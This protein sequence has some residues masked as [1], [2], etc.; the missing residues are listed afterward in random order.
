MEEMV[1][2]RKKRKVTCSWFLIIPEQGSVMQTKPQ[3]VSFLQFLGMVCLLS[4]FSKQTGLL[5]VKEKFHANE[6]SHWKEWIVSG[7]RPKKKS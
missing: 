4:A 5:T 2:I 3:K 6:T 7:W 1:W